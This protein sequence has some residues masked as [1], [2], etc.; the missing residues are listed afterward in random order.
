M[1]SLP[2]PD[3]EPV[4][5]RRALRAAATLFVFSGLAALV[6]QVAWQ[7][8]L[9]LHAGVSVHSVAL[10]VGSFMAGL[11]LGSHLGG[12]LSRRL[13]RGSALVAFAL[14]ELGVGLFAVA[15]AWLYYDVLYLRASGLYG[16]PW[17]AALLHFL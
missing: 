11:G 16:V 8:I 6:Y 12:L 15:S 10:I 5:E 14:V 4:L 7:R 1:S 2:S 17:R 3:L 9:A 13:E